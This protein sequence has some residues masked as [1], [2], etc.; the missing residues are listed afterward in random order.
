M[1]PESP[2]DLRRLRQFVA[3][4]QASSLAS[5]AATLF[6]SQQALSTAMRQLEIDLD[7]ALFDRSGRRMRLTAAGDELYLGAR[8]LL[9]GAEQL[10]ERVCATAIGSAHAF[11]VGHSPAISGEEVFDLITRTLGDHPGASITARQMFPGDM[12][13][14]LFDGTID[15]GV[16]RGVETPSDLAAAVI[17]YHRVRIAVAADHPLA[18]RSEVSIADLAEFEIVVWSPPHHSYYTDFLVSSCRRAGFEPRLVVNPIQGTPPM[19]AV[20]GSLRCAFVTDPAGPGLSGRVAVIDFDVP[21]LAPVQALW[22]PHTVSAIRDAILNGPRPHS[23][24]G[25]VRS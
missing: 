3:V 17:D 22:L 6:V 11:V 5:A 2:L 12:R 19:T 9:A 15:L 25:S 21:P 23:Q 14:Q 1:S 13:T 18:D 8:P 16:R 4:A 24:T 7:V 10:A 20:I